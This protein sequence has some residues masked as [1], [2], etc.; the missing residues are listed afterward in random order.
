MAIESFLDPVLGWLLPLPMWLS[1]LIFAVFMTLVITLV[2]KYMTDQKEMKRL[3]EKVKSSQEEM[4]KYRDEPK[5]LAKIQQEAMQTNMKYTMKS[6]KPTLYTILPFLILIAWMS[7]HYSLAAI[8][9]NTPVMV[10][11]QLEQPGRVTLTSDATVLGNAT[12]ATVEKQVYW[13]VKG[14]PGNHTL[15]FTSSGVSVTQ[16]LIIGSTP[17]QKI[18]KQGSPFVETQVDYPKATPFGDF[19]IFGYMP[20]WLMTYFLYSIVLSIGIRKIMKVY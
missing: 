13:E 5:K 10:H 3:K 1:L 20:G 6:L 11:V 14:P 17:T 15:N 4:K 18:V 19:S 12:K 8:P 7:A 2:Q 16:D 9:P